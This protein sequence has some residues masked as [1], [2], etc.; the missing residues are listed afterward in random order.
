MSSFGTLFVILN[1]KKDA[2]II[3]AAYAIDVLEYNCSSFGG[4]GGNRALKNNLVRF[5]GMI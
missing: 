3:P 5:A 4:Y 2:G 1:C